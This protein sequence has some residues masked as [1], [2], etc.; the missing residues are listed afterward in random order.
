MLINVV[1]KIYNDSA[2][3]P[4]NF[5]ETARYAGAKVADE[6][7]TT[8]IKDCVSE[9]EKEFIPLGDKNKAVG[10]TT[11]S[12]VQKYVRAMAEQA[13]KQLSDG[14]IIPS[15]YHGTCEYC[16]FAPMCRGGLVERKV[17]GVDTA[18][19]EESAN[20]VSGEVSDTDGE[21]LK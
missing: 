12:A 20:T 10:A 13:A 16:D 21:K 19:I 7:L 5:R 18:L 8:L 11:L 9:S 15:P 3:A 1:K 2:Q 14:V 4:V 17:S 6:A